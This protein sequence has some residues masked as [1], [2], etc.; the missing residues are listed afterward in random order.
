MASDPVWRENFAF[1]D[2]PAGE[3][4][5]ILDVNNG[6]YKF[7]REIEV[8]PGQTRFEVISTNFEFV[9]TPTAVPSPTPTGTPLPT[10]PAPEG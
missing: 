6:Q 10:F 8:L 4:E 9:P 3:Y 5:L 7:K 1:G 2:V